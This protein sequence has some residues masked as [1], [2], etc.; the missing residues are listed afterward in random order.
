MGIALEMQYYG[1][2]SG[3]KMEYPGSTLSAEATWPG[4]NVF[5]QVAE[6]LFGIAFTLEIVL[7]LVVLGRRFLKDTGNL[8]DLFIVFCWLSQNLATVS[9]PVQPAPL[10]LIRLIRLLR[11]LRLIRQIRGLGLL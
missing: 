4:A 10:R 6:N 5:F 3:H 8:F 2:E 7:K 9:F 11:I 1:I